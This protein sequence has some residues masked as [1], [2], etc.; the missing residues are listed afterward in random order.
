MKNISIY[1]NYQYRRVIISVSVYYKVKEK[2]ESKLSI[3]DTH[4]DKSLI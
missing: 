2:D 4:H 3:L 1:T